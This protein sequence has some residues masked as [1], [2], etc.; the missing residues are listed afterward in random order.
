MRKSH[1]LLC[2]AAN[3]GS[4]IRGVDRDKIVANKEG[5]SSPASERRMSR[6]SSLD[7]CHFTKLMM[8]L[9]RM[10]YGNKATWQSVCRVESE[11]R[12]KEGSRPLMHDFTLGG[13][14]QLFGAGEAVA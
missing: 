14:M 6:I 8:E 5:Q 2:L 12:V 7:D 1:L 4:S 11:N 3:K 13:S 10:G 9:K